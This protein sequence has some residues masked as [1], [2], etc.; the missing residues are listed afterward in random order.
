MTPIEVLITNGPHLVLINS[1]KYNLSRVIIAKDGDKF[2]L[3]VFSKWYTFHNQNYKTIAEAKKAFAVEFHHWAEPLD[4]TPDWREMSLPI[5]PAAGKK[6]RKD[7]DHEGTKGAK[8]KEKNGW[9][10][11]CNRAHLTPANPGPE[12]YF[13]SV[14]RAFVVKKGYKT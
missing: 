9:R 7:L 10:T 8:E 12:A 3:N 4:I 13:L 2:R 5:P 11:V 14:L 6:K 1:N